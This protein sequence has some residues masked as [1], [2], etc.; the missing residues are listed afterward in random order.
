MNGSGVRSE[1]D[2]ELPTLERRGNK[3]TA[4]KQGMMQEFLTG[5]IRL[6]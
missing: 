3:V 4:L 1:I 6:I 5:R 2:V